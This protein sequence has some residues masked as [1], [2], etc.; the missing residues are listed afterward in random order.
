MPLS[1]RLALTVSAGVAAG[2]FLDS[3]V[4]VPVP[5]IIAAGGLTALAARGRGRARVAWAAALVALAGLCAVAGASAQDRALHPPLRAILEQRVGGFAIEGVDGPRDDTPIV[6]EGRLQADAT[7]TDTGA[8]M[9]VQVER[10]WLGP[11]PESAPGG[12]SIGVSGSLAALAVQDWRAGRAIKAPVQLRRPARYLNA[13]VPDQERLLARRGLALVGSIKSA[14]LVDVTARGH[15]LDEA[16]AGARAAVRAA[17][18][19]HVGARAPQSAAIATAILIGDR[20]SLDAGVERRLQE[21]GT[22]HVIAISGGN[23]AILAGL[24]LVS[25]RWLRVRAGW[26][27]GIAITVLAG[28]AF[29][30]GGGPSVV[31]ATL[32]AA[33]YLSLRMIDQRTAPE[34]AMALTAAALLL[35]SPLAIADVGFW[36]TFGATAAIVIGP[37][38]APLP[39]TAWLRAPVVLVLASACAEAALMPVGA[40]VFQRVTLAGLAL[41]LAAVPCMAIVQVGAMVTAGADA[42]GLAPVASAAGWV[43]HLA[44][45]GLVDSAALVDFAPWIT[46]RVPSPSI[47]TV[48]AYYACLIAWLVGSLHHEVHEV[49]HEGH[50]RRPMIL[51]ALRDLSSCALWSAFGLF[52]WIAIAPPTLARVFGD[53]RLHLTM[54]DVGQGDAML[55]TF[56]NG[57]T[58]MVDTGGVSIRGDFDIGDRVLGPALRARRV[59]RLDYLSFTHGDPDHIGGAPSLAKDFSPLEIWDGVYVAGHEPTNRLRAAAVERRAAWRSLQRGDR[60]EIGGVELR[61]HHP[62]LADWERQKVRNDDSLVIELRYGQVS[63]LLTGDIGREV[64]QALIPALDLLPIVVLKSPHHGSGTSSSKEFIDAVKPAVVVISC[65]RG[66]PYGH[67]VPY[68]LERYRAVGAQVFRTDLEGQIE[69]TTD[70]TTLAAITFT[71]RRFGPP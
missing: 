43:T 20:G 15:W 10:I 4:L 48:V 58:L 2:V 49:N 6:L 1:I 28:Y 5:W 46:W 54:M 7:P 63:M 59:G 53:G 29:L 37:S 3:R 9:R 67:P 42:M 14:A 22:Y 33:V 36:L 55:V 17:M 69:V 25:L 40:M 16:A 71:G 60:L 66:N 13:G 65:G 45:R 51:R 23:I 62:P 70:G 41:N 68:V 34:H 21:A 31:R 8:T 30:A 61:V 57:R 44:V 26:A 27:A 11:C 24:V 12:V 19:R 50:E 39:A 32:M 56:P 35:V 38:R 64:E 52:L 47:L 18:A